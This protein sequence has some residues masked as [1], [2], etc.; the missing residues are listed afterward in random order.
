LLE[1]EVNMKKILRFLIQII[2]LGVIV[3]FNSCVTNKPLSKLNI[4]QISNLKIVRNETPEIKQFTLGG[5]LL[6]L[7]I[8]GGIGSYAAMSNG[9]ITSKDYGE[10]IMY[11]FADRAQKEIQNWPNM[12]IESK[13][14]KNSFKFN[15]GTLLVFNVGVVMVHARGG[16]MSITRAKMV[17]PDGKVLWQKKY[18]Y[19]GRKN[20][21]FHKVREFNNDSKLLSEEIDFAANTTVSEFIND[22]KNAN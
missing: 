2:L 1:K 8:G 7:A 14:V 21:R 13:P 6:G 3:L 16:F 18:L 11:R 5:Q 15:S 12:A 20:G 10:I 22:L 9:P 17:Q 4:T 19:E